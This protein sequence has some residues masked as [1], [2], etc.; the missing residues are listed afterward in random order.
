MRR[1]R[2]QLS[3]SGASARAVFENANLRWLELA[4]AAAIFG[5]YAYL[6]AVS[7]Y[8][9]DVGGEA[10]VGLVFLARLIPAA[11]A[12]PFAG[13]LGDRYRRERVMLVTNLARIVLVTVAGLGVL[14]GAPSVVVYLLAVAATI[15][16]TPFRSAQAALTPSLARNPSELTAANAHAA[17][18][19]RPVRKSRPD[20]TDAALADQ[21][22]LPGPDY[23]AS[24][25]RSKGEATESSDGGLFAVGEPIDGALTTVTEVAVVGDVVR[26]R[27]AA[28]GQPPGSVHPH[29]LRRRAA[30]TDDVVIAATV[31]HPA[32]DIET[33]RINASRLGFPFRLLPGTGQKARPVPVPDARSRLTVIERALELARRNGS[34]LPNVRLNGSDSEGPANV[35]GTDEL[36]VATAKAED[37]PAVEPTR[38]RASRYDH[39]VAP[40]PNEGATKHVGDCIPTIEGG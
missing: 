2:S 1:H 32:I 28:D 4:W 39:G 33:R 25:S 16:T 15:A 23:G 11:L 36:P 40:G 35:A 8:A 34:R 37:R 31:E 6:I 12:S 17:F 29:L 38:A 7:V 19:A 26:R 10:A 18:V 13:M 9:Y 14:L 24:H 22:A 27:V 20:A 21:E 3:G 30:L 5:H